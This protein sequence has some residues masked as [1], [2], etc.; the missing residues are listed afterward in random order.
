MAC[1][2]PGSSVHGFLQARRLQWLA[3][4][5]SR[6]L[7]DLGIELVSPALQADSLLLGQLGSPCYSLHPIKLSKPVNCKLFI[8][9]C[10]AFPEEQPVKTVANTL[11]LACCFCLCGALGLSRVALHGMAYLLILVPVSTIKFVFLTLSC[12]SSCGWI[13][14]W[15]KR[16]Q[17][18]YTYVSVSVYTHTYTYVITHLSIGSVTIKITWGIFKSLPC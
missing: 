1:S 12:V 18:L 8:L 3:I 16:A 17:N 9:P 6:D 14:P 13:W 2:P 15:H 10:Q 4:F 11:P 7:P 5:F